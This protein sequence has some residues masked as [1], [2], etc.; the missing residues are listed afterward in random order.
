VAEAARRGLLIDFGGVLTTD[1]FGSFAAFCD[2]AGLD[3]Q[4][5]ARRFRHDPPTRDLLIGLEEGTLAPADFEARLAPLL[6]VEPEGLI[7]RLMA[8]AR[9]DEAMIDAVR[10]AR[11]AGVRTGLISNSWGVERYDSEL[12]SE[13]FDGVVL[14]GDVGL[15][16]PSR[17]MYELGAE[18]V[19]LAPEECVFV[20]DLGFNLKPAAEMGMATIKHERAPE[21]IAAL[22]RALGVALR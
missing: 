7:E 19:G 16:K 21:T 20:D 5:L 9:P 2:D 15:R 10:A 14:S 13:L 4:E 8:R 6:G 12:L 17:R 3:P 22:E 1:V 18:A 11:A